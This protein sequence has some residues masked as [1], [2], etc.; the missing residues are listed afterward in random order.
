MLKTQG[1]HIPM[2]EAA[3]VRALL[4]RR[5]SG[6]RGFEDQNFTFKSFRQ[7]VS[8]VYEFSIDTP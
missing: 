1:F 5:C 6:M 3:G 4:E 2:V 7:Y 8:I